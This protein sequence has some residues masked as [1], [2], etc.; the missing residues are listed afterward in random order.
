M[1]TQREHLAEETGT[2]P[3]DW[4]PVAKNTHRYKLGYRWW[5]RTTNQY[6]KLGSRNEKAN[7]GDIPPAA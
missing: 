2:A 5:N 7:E 4:V 6:A 1:K 3:D